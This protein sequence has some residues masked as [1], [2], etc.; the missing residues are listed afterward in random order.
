MFNLE[1]LI[2]DRTQSDVDN[3]TAKGFYNL[4][5]LQRINAYIE[6]LSEKLS[7]EITPV[8]FQLGD[9]I[10]LEKINQ[11]LYNIRVIKEKWH[12]ANDTPAL[13]IASGLNFAGANAIEK[14]LLALSEF[15]FSFEVDKKYSGT[16]VAGQEI[17]F[18]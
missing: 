14:N 16:F 2:T 11:V 6:Y 4:S 7:I 1:D 17:V 10:T 15:L 18:V 9:A 12:V 8:A 5:D 13:P 3:R